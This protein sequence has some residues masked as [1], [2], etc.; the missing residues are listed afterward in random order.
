MLFA[1][2]VACSD[3]NLDFDNGPSSKRNTDEQDDIIFDDTSIPVDSEPVKRWTK[4][5]RTKLKMMV[6]SM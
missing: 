3:Q 5:K 4:V 2:T 1:I 6:L